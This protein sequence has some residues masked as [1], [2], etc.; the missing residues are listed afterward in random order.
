MNR[1]LLG[2]LCLCAIQLV[3]CAAYEGVQSKPE[4]RLISRTDHL[5]QLAR[6]P[7]LAVHP[8]GELFIAGF[9]SQVT[10]RDWTAPPLLWRSDDSG[11]TWERLDVG[12]REENAQG[13]SDVD[14]AMSSD[15]HL[16]F[17]SMGFDRDTRE[18]VQIHVGRSSDKGETWSW[19]Q[20]S[21]TR[22][23]DRPWISVTPN[24]SVHLIWNDGAGVRHA[25][26]DTTSDGLNERKR[27]SESGGS[28]HFATRGDALLAARIVPLS[29]SANRFDAETDLIAVSSDAGE[30]WVFR[31]TPAPIDWTFSEEA[32]PRWI[33]PIAWSDNDT[34]HYLWADKRKVFLASSTDFGET[35]SIAE[36]SE[37]DGKPF[38][39]FLV[40]D[41]ANRLAATWFVQESDAIS[42]RV[43]LVEVQADNNPPL[44]SSPVS[45]QPEIWAETPDEKTPSTGGEYL[46]TAF[47]DDGV[48]AVASPIQNTH[49]DRWG[50]SFWK[51]GVES[52]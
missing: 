5:G 37:H 42:A 35:W 31:D 45:F 41:G 4:L 15:G 6:E 20:V 17:A 32:T 27:I 44:I 14:L 11:E 1:Y 16:L 23:D 47:M 8:D 38:F 2:I 28:S 25:V 43:A 33:E 50:F 24:Q 3:G 51:F 34:L 13:N 22:F 29:A 10:A 26:G 36:V 40:S 18:G 49:E 9:G 12:D 7:M 39:P 48:I 30:T 19:S 52:D 46:T 21:R